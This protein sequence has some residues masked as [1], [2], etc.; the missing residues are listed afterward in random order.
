MLSPGGKKNL[1]IFPMNL[2]FVDDKNFLQPLEVFE[3]AKMASL[4][5][6]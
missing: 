3:R 5:Y 6:N 2:T 1:I 4:Y